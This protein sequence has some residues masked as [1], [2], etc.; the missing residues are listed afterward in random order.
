MPT[1]AVRIHENN[2]N[3]TLDQQIRL[4]GIAV[5]DGFTDPFSQI[6][7]GT[8]LYN[9]GFVDRLGR[10]RLEVQELTVHNLIAKGK[11]YEAFQV[12]SSRNMTI[13][14]ATCNPKT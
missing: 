14:F 5:G 12:M 8:F 1:L 13:E 2:R 9:L 3:M 7:F 10:K 11:Y 4:R 6:Q